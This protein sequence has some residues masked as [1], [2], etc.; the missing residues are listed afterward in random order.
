MAPKTDPPRLTVAQDNAVNRS[1]RALIEGGWDH[2]TEPPAITDL[3]AFETWSHEEILKALDSAD[4][5][6]INSMADSWRNVTEQGKAAHKTFADTLPTALSASWEGASGAAATAAVRAYT[7]QAGHLLASM[8]LVANDLDRTESVL[9]ETKDK[10]PQDTPTKSTPPSAESAREAEAE[11][12]RVMRTLYQPGVQ[13]VDSRTPRLPEPQPLGGGSAQ[14]VGGE[15]GNASSAAGGSGNSAIPGSASGDGTATQAAT[16]NPA[17]T[18]GSAT[19]SAAQLG[20]GA[21]ASS[22]SHPSASSAGLA[23]SA[24]GALAAAPRLGASPG[25]S[26]AG[27]LP[28]SAGGLGGVGRNGQPMSG[29]FP[30]LARG[31]GEEEEQRKSSEYLVA[32][33]NTSE[34]V[35]DLPM[36]TQPVLGE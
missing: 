29:M 2:E 33:S 31:K 3:E 6:C 20:G 18:S 30:P 14:G 11:A 16:F 27:S 10:V 17:S 15:A 9:R 36:A 21:G 7:E 5:N 25:R 19:S 34:L 8:Q 22:S 23:G 26:V 13:E 12:R 24:A 28:G 4:P 35:G 32:A 1:E